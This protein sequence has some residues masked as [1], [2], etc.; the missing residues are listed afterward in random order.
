MSQTT[1]NPQS[2]EDYKAN[3]EAGLAAIGAQESAPTNLVTPD[4]QTTTLPAGL[5]KKIRVN[6]AFIRD[7]DDE[8]KPFLVD[9]A[10]Y[11]LVEITG[12]SRLVWSAED[13]RHGCT[14]K[15]VWIET[16]AEVK[17]GL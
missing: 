15:S 9:G 11:A 5:T 17:V 3:R 16:E 6:Q 13:D 12:P 2:Y 10:Q 8:A 4:V 1:K 7:Y 14:V